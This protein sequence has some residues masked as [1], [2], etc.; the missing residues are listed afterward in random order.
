[1][2]NVERHWVGR[3]E[4]FPQNQTIPNFKTHEKVER[5]VKKFGVSGS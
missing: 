2:T 3:R 5:T 4:T 1:M